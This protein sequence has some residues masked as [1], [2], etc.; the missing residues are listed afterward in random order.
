[1]VIHLL[2]L[3]N[4]HGPSSTASDWPVIGQFSSIGRLGANSANWLTGEF[5]ISLSTTVGSNA[6]NKPPLNLV[7]ISGQI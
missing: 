6:R 2:Q 5:L 3:L 7:S 4:E 1:M